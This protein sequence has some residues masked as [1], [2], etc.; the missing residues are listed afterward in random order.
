M[1]EQNPVLEITEISRPTIKV[2]GKTYQLRYQNEF[3]IIEE[4]RLG[5]LHAALQERPESE[6]GAVKR[7]KML[8]DLVLM[9]VVEAEDL[10]TVLNDYQKGQVLQA[11][12]AVPLPGQAKTPPAETTG[13]NEP[14]LSK[15]ADSS[16]SMEE[17]PLAG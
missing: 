8:N 3:S 9:I 12:L 2:N 10:L 17:V 13:L 14:L 4:Y 7:Q 16:V 11:F 15:S 5:K 6:E 1:A